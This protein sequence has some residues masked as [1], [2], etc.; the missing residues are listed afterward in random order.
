MYR[1]F[2]FARVARLGTARF[3]GTTPAVDRAAIHTSPEPDSAPMG[4]VAL[5]GDKTLNA[6]AAA[7]STLDK[8]FRDIDEMK[9]STAEI[10]ASLGKV[11]RYYQQK[12]VADRRAHKRQ[13]I[14][15]VVQL[16]QVVKVSATTW[17]VRSH[18]A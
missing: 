15:S 16:A 11:L 13:A 9:A 7:M 10:K 18:S 14:L 5:Q 1:A 8:T 6:P 17:R 2:H 4:V 3:F 12:E